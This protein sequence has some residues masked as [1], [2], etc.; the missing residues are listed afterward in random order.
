MAFPV[1]AG[2]T[3][4]S[5]PGLDATSRA[6][7]LD[8]L[9]A[10]LQDH[11]IEADTARMIAEGIRRRQR[12]GAYDRITDPSAFADTVTRDLRRLNGD[13]HLSL[14]HELP[15][16]GGGPVVVRTV[17]AP[18][19]GTSAGGAH[20]PVRP[21]GPG[22]PG[23]PAM[24]PPPWERQARE[25]NFGLGH[26]EIL[27]GNVGYLEI[28]GFMGA[29]GYEEAVA[30]ALRLLER[31]DAVIIDVRRNGGGSGAMSHLVFSHFLPGEP[32]P[33]IRVRNR[34]EGTD[35]V[36]RSLAQVPGPRR[37]AVPL[38]VLT[39]RGT[40]SA[41]EEF[42]FVL[43]NQRR[44]TIVGE[45]TAG[46]GH[47]VAGF[48]LPHGFVAGV[49]ITRVSDPV[50]GREWETV[51]VPVD[52]E[53][54]PLHALATAHAAAL[55]ALAARAEDA[56]RRRTLEATAEWVEARERA[57]VVEPPRLSAIAGDYADGRSVE[58]VGGRPFYRRRP[59]ELPTELIPLG[60]DRFALG[61]EIRL[62]FAPGTPAPHIVVER[63]DGSTLRIERATARDRGM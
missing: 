10:R 17:G 58:I 38:Y 59:G 2:A 34:G 13:L 5:V 12:A 28:T 29:P 57:L 60:G 18:A 26:V 22:T 7:V 62:A 32:V 14:R 48:T 20:G 23:G 37:P 8:T 9:V 1:A 43:R 55:R 45:R 33:T 50:S 6:Q 35:T 31:A 52:L 19:A 15:G 4:A 40:G 41:A 16:Q 56:A 24:A 21:A 27:P 36:F 49:S 44:A 47:M 25:Q 46:A 54:D 42:T 61:P 39:S 51:G 11:Y 63:P 3:P 30:S 53:V